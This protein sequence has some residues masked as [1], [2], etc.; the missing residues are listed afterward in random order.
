M[1]TQR[2]LHEAPRYDGGLAGIGP[3]RKHGGIKSCQRMAQRFSAC[4]D[5]SGSFLIAMFS[6]QE[7]H[8]AEDIPFAFTSTSPS[9]KTTPS[10]VR[11]D[12]GPIDRDSDASKMVFASEER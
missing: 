10:R 4:L 3:D 5:A 11:L 2:L 1:A 6:D 7:R 9:G 8:R 12:P